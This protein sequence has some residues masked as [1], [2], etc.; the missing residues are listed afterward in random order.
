MKLRKKTRKFQKSESEDSQDFSD[1][2][3]NKGHND[4]DDQPMNKSAL[5][6]VGTSK[7]LANY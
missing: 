4:M 5:S 1:H 6:V 2:L 3:S 7:F